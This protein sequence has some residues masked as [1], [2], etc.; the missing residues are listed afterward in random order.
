MFG[1]M[2]LI[3]QNSFENTVFKGT[4]ACRYKNTLINTQP[5]ATVCIIIFKIVVFN[6][7]CNL[8]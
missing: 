3:L 2:V 5:T 6:S 1:R 7:L 8:N 4:S